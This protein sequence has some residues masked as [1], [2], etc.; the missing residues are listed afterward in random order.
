[1]RR[2]E[3]ETTG[4]S[5]R[6]VIGD[7]TFRTKE[8]VE[9]HIQQILYAY[10][11]EEMVNSEDTRFLLALL[12]NHPKAEEKCGCGIR[13]FQIRQNQRFTT[14]R[15]FYLLRLQ[16]EAKRLSHHIPSVAGR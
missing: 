4:K 3:Q 13:A 1:M 9:R 10:Q 7:A 6:Y 15:G 2:N 5:R 14:K 12:C 8:E 11:V 16:R